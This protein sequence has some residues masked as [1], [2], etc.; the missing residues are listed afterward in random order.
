MPLLKNAGEF[1]ENDLF[2]SLKFYKDYIFNEPDDFI[3]DQFE[4][5]ETYLTRAKAGIPL[6]SGEST[7]TMA[8]Y[9]TDPLLGLSR[10]VV[11]LP[12]PNTYKRG[13]IATILD[14]SRHFYMYVDRQTKINFGTMFE[15]SV[16]MSLN[17]QDITTLLQASRAMIQP[18]SDLLRFATKLSNE[19]SVGNSNPTQNRDKTPTHEEYAVIQGMRLYVRSCSIIYDTV[20]SGYN[21]TLGN[22]KQAL[23]ICEKAV[24]RL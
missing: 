2:S 14:A 1:T 20:S 7:P 8:E 4:A 23:T 5:M 22:V 12:R 21:F 18:A 17:K 3:M 24:K 9:S 15:G 13:N 10:L 11:R 19:G 6:N 16:N